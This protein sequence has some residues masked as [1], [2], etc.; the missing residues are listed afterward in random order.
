MHFDF[1]RLSD[2]GIIKDILEEA[3]V[4]EDSICLIEWGK[5]V[6]SVLPKDRLIININKDPKKV[7][8]RHIVFLYTTATKYLMRGIA[9]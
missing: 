3:I 1:Y 8:T 2:V 6:E 5:T 4:D 9:S 7:M